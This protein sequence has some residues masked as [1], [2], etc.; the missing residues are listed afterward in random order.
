MA[1]SPA[2]STRALLERH[3]LRAKKAWGQNFLHDE[4]VVD[5]IV[6]SAL[7]GPG[8]VV[9]EI[10]AGTG[11]LTRR[12]AAT[13]ANVTAIE[14]DPDLIPVLEQELADLPNVRLLAADALTF[15]LAEAARAAGRPIVV[16][17]NLPYQITSP[18]LFRIVGAATNSDAIARAVLMV[19]KEV[20]DR[21]VAPPG[22]KTYG[23]LS[24][25]VQA[26]AEVRIQFNVGPGAFLPPPTVTS[27]VF[28]LVPRATN[29]VAPAERGLFAAVVRAAFAGRRKM[30]R[31]SLAIG[32]SAEVLSAAFAAAGVASTQRAEEL[33]VAAFSRLTHAL[34][35]GGVAANALAVG[36]DESETAEAGADDA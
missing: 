26:A 14:R 27:S 9:V 19:Q 31:R 2:L 34:A 28:S 18:L 32:L 13:G 25:M 15:D 20:A 17:G 8:D 35:V 24:V 33:D 36:S 11:A 29:L 3:G 23:R 30:L 7:L 22:S 6:K 21:I 12:L 10:G 16:L 1:E 5:R 4:R